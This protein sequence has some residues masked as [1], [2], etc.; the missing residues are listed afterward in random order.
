MFRKVPGTERKRE[1]QSTMVIGIGHYGR[2]STATEAIHG[3][4]T[5]LDIIEERGTVDF[6]MKPYELG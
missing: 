3:G 2:N 4:I 5:S 6:A 1:R